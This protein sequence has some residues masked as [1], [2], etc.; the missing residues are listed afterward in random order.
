MSKW[1]VLLPQP[2][3][4]K[5]LDLLRSRKEFSVVVLT[6][7]ERE[8]VREFLP[9][10]HALIVRSGF[11]VDREILD[12]A[13][14]LQVICR[15]G[16]GLDNIDVEYARER[17]VQV[18]NVPGGN[19]SSVAEHTIALLLALAKSLFFYDRRTREGDWGIRH[20]YKA[21]EVAGKILGLVGFGTIGREVARLAL[22]LGL[23]V[24]FYDPF[25]E[26]ETFSQAEK[27]ADLFELLSQS[28]FVSLH[29]PLTKDTRHLIAE[30]ELRL[31]KREAFLINVSRGAVVDEEALF[32]A[33]QEGW[34]AGAALDVFC[35]EPPSKDSPLFS[36]ENV[37]VTPH[38]A[39]LTRESAER[40]A[41]RAVEKV[42]E[43]FS[44]RRGE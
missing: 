19:V 29:V 21:I 27:K 28:D 37:V 12:H 5:A 44:E 36:L 13:P 8:R 16:V 25:V 39:G 35:N 41:L 40:V 10:A 17:G 14:K 38:V 15:A 26:G 43:F 32:K 31:M 20:S 18:F 30:R 6:P 3:A 1:G 9:Q 11:K 7:Q 22:S 33:L 42:I 24:L 34:I 2:I 4:G 23:K